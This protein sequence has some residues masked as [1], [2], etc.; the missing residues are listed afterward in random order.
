MVNSGELNFRRHLIY[1]SVATN[2]LIDAFNNASSPFVV[3]ASSAS[4]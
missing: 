1:V 3:A 2:L 4:F